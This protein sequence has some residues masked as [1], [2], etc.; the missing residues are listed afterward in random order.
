M[1]ALVGGARLG[2]TRLLHGRALV[3]PAVAGL[4]VVVAAALERVVAPSQAADHALAGATFGLA[5]PLLAFVTLDRATGRARLDAAVWE[6]ARYGGDR[7]QGAAGLIGVSALFLGLCGAA[8]AALAVIVTRSSGDATLARDLLASAWVGLLGGLCYGCWFALGS[9]F[10]AAGRGR[11]VA[12][13]L[14]WVLGSGSTA[15]AAL[16]PRGHLRNLLGAEPVLHMPQWSA[17][18]AVLALSLGYA[19]AT[20]WRV[21][22]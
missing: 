20:L 1:T 10:G 17:L 4:F 14:D 2:A 7:R 18:A 22:R 21:S 3:A 15:L 9:G 6:V 8:L 11:T 12:L 19:T 16:W 5:L 13:L